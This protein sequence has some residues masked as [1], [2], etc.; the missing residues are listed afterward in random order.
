MFA[1]KVET[2]SMKLGGIRNLPPTERET[3][4]NLN[5]YSTK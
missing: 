3:Q 4:S 5:R 2:R 1:S